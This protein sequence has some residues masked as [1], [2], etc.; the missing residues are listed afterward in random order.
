MQGQHKVIV[1]TR[2]LF[3]VQ[4]YRIHVSYFHQKPRIIYLHH[5]DGLIRA[6]FGHHS[7]KWIFALLKRLTKDKL[8][9]CLVILSHELNHNHR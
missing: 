7:P 2:P 8:T 6:E 5:V 4:I 9:N 1:K 3:L